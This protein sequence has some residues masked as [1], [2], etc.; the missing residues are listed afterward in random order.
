MHQQGVAVPWGVLEV[1]RLLLQEA[2][3]L[4]VYPQHVVLRQPHLQRGLLEGLQL[5]GPE[6]DLRGD[7]LELLRMAQRQGVVQAVSIL[8]RR[9]SHDV[10]VIVVVHQ[11]GVL[12]GPGDAMDLEGAPLPHPK[13]NVR[14]CGLEYNLCAVF[15]QELLV[16]RRLDV[17]LNAVA[18]VSVDVHLRR[19]GGKVR[20][21]LL[22]GD[23]SPREQA[24][25]LQ[26][27]LA[28]ALAGRVQ[29]VVPE[30]QQGAGVLGV[31]VQ[32]ERDDVDLRV[33]EVVPVVALPS[34]AL[35]A[36]VGAPLAAHGLQQVEQVEADP[37]LQVAIPPD[38][39]VRGLPEVLEEHAVLGA[40]RFVAQLLGLRHD[41]LGGAVELVLIHIT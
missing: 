19:A 3:I 15:Q 4:G 6:V 11:R 20:A 12:V 28:G 1:P 30:H 14:P 7:G 35:G 26:V 21:A 31:G 8:Q 10:G 24:P 34:E 32:E 2:V 40:D 33:P 23:R 36:D 25:F 17:A 41:G 37:L 18:D 9:L 29:S 38:L 39:N 22:S 27:D 5:C 16:I 13:L